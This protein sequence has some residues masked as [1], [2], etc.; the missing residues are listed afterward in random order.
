MTELTLKIS[1]TDDQ[2][3]M[4]ADAFSLNK[5]PEGNGEEKYYSPSQLSHLFPHSQ[6]KF[7]KWIR[8]RA[9]GTYA[10]DGRMMATYK[11]AKEFLEYKK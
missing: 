10:R 7:Q 4:L 6:W 9:F 1:L 5:S 3:Q 8:E 11:Q 2:V